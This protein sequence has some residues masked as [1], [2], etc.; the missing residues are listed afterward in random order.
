MY[1]VD[2]QS[3]ERLYPSNTAVAAGRQFYLVC[4]YHSARVTPVIS[5]RFLRASTFADKLIYNE[6]HLSPEFGDF[7]VHSTADGISNLTKRISNMHDAGTY[8]CIQKDGDRFV[9]S[10]AQVIVFGEFHIGLPVFS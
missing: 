10:S 1:I 9:V 6:T 5:W 7:Q 8:R 3:N 4:E 2:G